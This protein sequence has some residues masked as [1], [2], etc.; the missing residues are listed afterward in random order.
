[1]D[2][3]KHEPDV[4]IMDFEEDDTAVVLQAENAVPE[5]EQWAEELTASLL[6]LQMKD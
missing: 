4:E 1:M 2:L 5:P 3:V 6:A